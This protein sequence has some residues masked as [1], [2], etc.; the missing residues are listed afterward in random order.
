[1]TSGYVGDQL[2]LIR[3]NTDNT[4]FSVDASTGAILEGISTNLILSF[5][6]DGLQF[7]QSRI[8]TVYPNAFVSE[9]IQDS[10][11]NQ[12]AY[13][14]DDNLFLN[15][16]IV[17]VEFSANGSLDKYYLL[18]PAGFLERNTASGDPVHHIRRNKELL[19]NPIVEHSNGKLRVNYYRA[20]D[21][22]NIRRGQ[23]TSKT[24]TT[25]L[26]DSDTWLDN[27]ALGDAQHICIVGSLGEVQDY[28]V[29]VSSYNSSTRTITIPSQTLTGD[30]GDYVVTGKYSST[31]LNESMPDRAWDYLRLYTSYRI[32][33]KDSSMD[34][35]N[36]RS[37]VKEVLQDIYDAYSETSGD[38]E[39]V[40]TLDSELT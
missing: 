23:I 2:D 34:F 6:N 37:D 22:L 25:I 21:K 10:V 4:P 35:I 31:H 20:I 27:F 3:E 33:K 16:K 39:G 7:L 13:T 24:S 15:N 9:N 18:P 5:L 29:V 17:S 30:T 38:V 14:V 11:A 8:I 1:M 26:L 19:L 32:F 28:N 40:P 12:E 36:E